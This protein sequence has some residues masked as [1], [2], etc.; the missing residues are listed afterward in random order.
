[1]TGTKNRTTRRR[2]L[3]D[4][5]SR[6]FGPLSPTLMVVP[7]SFHR[8]VKR[9]PLIVPSRSEIKRLWNESNFRLWIVPSQKFP[10]HSNDTGTMTK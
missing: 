10:A 3:F 1:M 2:R 9:G 8:S 6:P 4:P 5:R 7:T